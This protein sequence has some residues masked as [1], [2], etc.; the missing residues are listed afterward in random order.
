MRAGATSNVEGMLDGLV[1]TGIV[2]ILN[3]IAHRRLPY[4]KMLGLT[5]V[6]LGVVLLVMVGEEAQEMQ[7]AHWLPTMPIGAFQNVIP[8][9]AELWFAAFPTMET[10][11]AQAIAA[12]AVIGSYVWAGRFAR[13]ANQSMLALRL[14][15]FVFFRTSR[16]RIEIERQPKPVIQID[17]ARPTVAR[18]EN[19]SADGLSS[20]IHRRAPR[21]GKSLLF[22]VGTDV[23]HQPIL[24]NAYAHLPAHQ[25]TKSAH[26]ALFFYRQTPRGEISP[27]PLGQLLVVSHR[28]LFSDSPMTRHQFFK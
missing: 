5:G 8:D 13:R 25:K 23:S 6:M 18:N 28:H 11:L 21:T 14:E 2:A 9:W 7:L 1:L 16:L 27:C 4:R 24:F 19:E 12:V 22:A 17:G 3:F 15:L 26:H 20:E 10:L